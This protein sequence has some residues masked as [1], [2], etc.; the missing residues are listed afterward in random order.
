VNVFK[1]VMYSEHIANPTPQLRLGETPQGYVLTAPL[2]ERASELDLGYSNASFQGNY[3]FSII[4]GARDVTGFGATSSDGKGNF[5]GIQEINTGSGQLLKQRV[6]GTYQVF[7]DGT[8]VAHTDLTT[9]DGSTTRASF[10][11]VVL[12]AKV[13]G[14]VKLATQLRGMSREPAVDPSTGQPF[15]PPQIGVSLFERLPS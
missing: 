15:N 12:A 7:P 4:F 14:G 2:P 1:F 11:Y 13:V 3:N 8:G 10:D 6:V 5:S 9:P